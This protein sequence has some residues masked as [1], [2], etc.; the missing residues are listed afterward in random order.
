MVERDRK[1]IERVDTR[2]RDSRWTKSPLK[3]E[4]AEC[5][6]CDACMRACP[7]QFNAVFN[8]GLDVRIIPELCSGCDACLKACPVDCIYPDKNWVATT[9]QLWVRVRG[10]VIYGDQRSRAGGV[11]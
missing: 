4:H 5:I 2:E 11:D 6:G 1:I 3:I 9:D 8:D 7:V 10:E